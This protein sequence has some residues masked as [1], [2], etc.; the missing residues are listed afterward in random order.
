MQCSPA[1]STLIS[2]VYAPNLAT[3]WHRQ[4]RAVPD[5]FYFP[6]YLRRLGYYCTNNSKKD[7]NASQIPT[8]VWDQSDNT[9]SW[10]SA[11]QGK[12]FFAVYNSGITHMTR[13]VTRTTDGRSPR[14]I[15]PFEVNPPPI[16]PNTGEVR[17]DYAWHLDAVANMDSWIGE[18]LQE[19]QAAGKDD[20]TIIF[21]FSDHGGCLPGSKAY[22]SERGGRVPMLA[23]FPPA[24]AHLAPVNQPA[25]ID[26]FMQFI[27]LGAS[28][29][30]LA[31]GKVPDY[32]EGRAVLG[33]NRTSFRNE[34]FLFRTNQGD[35]FIPSRALINDRYHMVWNFNTAYPQGARQSYQWQMPAFM[36]W[37]KACLAGQCDSIQAAF[38]KPM[39]TFELYDLDSDPNELHNLA[40]NPQHAQ[41]LEDMKTALLAQLKSGPDLGFFPKNMRQ[42]S[43]STPFY[44]IV[45]N[46]SIDVDAV[47]D[48]AA[49]A[50][51]ASSQDL[52]QLE[53]MLDDPQAPVRYWAAMGLNRLISRKQIDTLSSNV[54][55][56]WSQVNEEKEIR[57]ILA[58]ALVRDG[59]DCEPLSY[60]LNEAGKNQGTA[61]MVLQN[62]GAKARR[63]ESRII[64]LKE[65]GQNV[66]RF[67][68][69]GAL[70]NSGNLPYEALYDNQITPIVINEDT[71]CLE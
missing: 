19:L 38:W 20:S 8:H 64:D 27:D 26:S 41:V 9:A 22:V 66:S 46:Q 70:I 24:F 47:I 28:M 7:Y 5:S 18:R 12:P 65:N 56:A 4:G 25:V 71:T 57:L 2:G 30:Q 54:Y 68:L 43:S 15:Q 21:F 61:N 55:T 32:M 62:L 3:D 6:I 45:R 13:V 51:Q 53:L 35:N 39:S 59:Q 63:L 48:A 52:P 42:R 58:E 34:V 10:V 33:S 11:P 50:S 31:G 36:S 23:Y 44:D 14:N 67:M 40:Y 17:D 60:I 37:E 49:F 69:R 16:L 1:R 29:I